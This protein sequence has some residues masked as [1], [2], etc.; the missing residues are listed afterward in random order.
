M[1]KYVDKMN[2]PQYRYFNNMLGKTAEIDDMVA[3]LLTA[4]EV[5]KRGG[6]KNRNE[7][8]LLLSKFQRRLPGFLYVREEDRK[9][10]RQ[11][12]IGK[13][14]NQLTKRLEQY[15]DIL[16]IL[17]CFQG[18][19]AEKK[20]F[21]EAKEQL[22]M[23]EEQLKKSYKYDKRTRKY[24]TSSTCIPK[25]LLVDEELHQDYAG[26]KYSEK[27]MEE[28]NKLMTKDVFYIINIQ[29][30]EQSDLAY[31]VEKSEDLYVRVLEKYGAKR[32]PVKRII[33]E[34]NA[35]TGVL[36]CLMDYLQQVEKAEKKRQKYNEE[37]PNENQSVKKT[38]STRRFEDKNAIKIY[39][40]KG[41]TGSS[42]F[43]GETYFLER[44]NG[45]SQR[46]VGYEMMPHTRKGHYRT[47]KNG[48]KVY[49]HSSIIH[50]ERYE[51]IQSAHRINQIEEKESEVVETDQSFSQGM[52]M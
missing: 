49:V 9:K 19:I 45:S 15:A 51:G 3:D 52:S 25:L 41:R 26:K 18:E 24:Y 21:L 46:K 50:K 32:I 40:M 37:H 30:K 14:Y 11:D 6:K 13:N 20:E 48:N 42:G 31:I 28:L 36:F 43:G 7:G 5:I 29:S 22:T 35:V 27:E 10:C 39:D 16:L 44:K 4:E 17:P 2:L 1:S 33:S 38:H 34:Q 8:M 12:L 23:A 47:Y